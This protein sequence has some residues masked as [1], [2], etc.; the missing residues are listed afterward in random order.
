MQET[1]A[2]R[3][4]AEP[5]N[6]SWRS[7]CI[8]GSSSRGTSRPPGSQLA[9]SSMLRRRSRQGVSTARQE[10]TGRSGCRI[11]SRAS[12]IGTSGQIPRRRRSGQSRSQLQGHHGNEGSCFIGWPRQHGRIERRCSRYIG[13][14]INLW[15][16]QAFLMTSTTSFRWSAD[17][18]A[19]CTANSTSE[20]YQRQRTEGSRIASHR[21][22]KRKM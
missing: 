21:V 1:D 19:G 2:R 11:E 9:S 12:P 7:A 5:S 4:S 8:A 17:M 18:S 16:R 22:E 6:K 13:S 14:A 3:R 10:S 20:R 15:P